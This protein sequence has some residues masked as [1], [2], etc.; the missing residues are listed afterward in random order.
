[1]TT[2]MRIEEVAAR[3]VAAVG[4]R[5]GRHEIG[6]EF[7]FALDKVREFLRTHGLNTS[8]RNIFI[9]RSKD[10]PAPDGKM[11]V[12]FGIEVSAPF[13]DDRDVICTTTPAG[14]IAVATHHGPYEA[15]ATVHAELQRW[16][17]ANDHAL[18]GVDWEIYGDW[19]DDPAKRETRVCYLLK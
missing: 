3:T 18:A 11:S 7:A 5:I 4:R 2:E 17:A 15:L 9:Y 19:N 6:S 13:P 12:E 1:M 16:C 10:T 14:S 8:G